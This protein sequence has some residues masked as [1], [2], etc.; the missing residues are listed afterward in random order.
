MCV[1]SADRQRSHSCLLFS[2]PCD[3]ETAGIQPPGHDSVSGVADKMSDWAG[4]SFPN[5]YMIF[6]FDFPVSVARHRT[7]HYYASVIRSHSCQAIAPTNTAQRCI[8][9]AARGPS[10]LRSVATSPP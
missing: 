3:D 2:E 7:A 9:C 4:E 8:S 6:T 10:W 1:Q 5:I